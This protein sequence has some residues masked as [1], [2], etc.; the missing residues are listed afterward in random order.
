VAHVEEAGQNNLNATAAN[1]GETGTL[2]DITE[3]MVGT[4]KV[5]CHVTADAEF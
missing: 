2:I 5:S 1:T 4:N 3:V